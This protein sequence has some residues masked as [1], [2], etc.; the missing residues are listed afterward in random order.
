MRKV[1]SYDFKPEKPLD[2]HV[3]SGSTI[4]LRETD[5]AGA[6]EAIV[7]GAA[8]E[9]WYILRKPKRVGKPNQTSHN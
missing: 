5:L 1:L 6:A 4:P 9:P 2:G 8:R 3:F 7:V